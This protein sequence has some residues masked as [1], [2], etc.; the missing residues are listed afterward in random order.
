MN[1]IQ[2]NRCSSPERKIRSQQIPYFRLKCERRDPVF[3][4]AQS[5]HTERQFPDIVIFKAIGIKGN[6]ETTGERSAI[7]TLTAEM[8]C[9]V[10][11]FLIDPQTALFEKFNFIPVG[12]ADVT[13]GDR[14][15][16]PRH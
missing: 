11:L 10:C 16:F 14:A 12:K 13:A 4:Q 1:G 6:P 9:K 8:R 7:K 5:Q 2:L 3:I 15:A